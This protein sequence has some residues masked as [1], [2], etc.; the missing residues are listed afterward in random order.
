MPDARSVS[1]GIWVG[2]GGRDEAPALAGASHFLEHLLFKGTEER[3]A[4]EIAEAVDAVGGEMN[5]YTTLE[6]TAFDTRLP[7]GHLELGSTCCATSSPARVPRR[8]PGGRAPGHPRG[9]VD[10]GGHADDRVLGVLA[11]AQFPGTRS[12]GRCSARRETIAAMGGDAIRAFHGEWYRP[13]NLVVACAGAVDH[14][15]VVAGVERRI[16]RLRGG[17]PPERSAP[18][19]P[20]LPLKVLRRRTEQ[21]HLAVGARALQRD[22]PDRIALAVA[23]QA[24]GGGLSS[25]LFQEIRERRGL[26]YSVYSYATSWSDAGALVV[27][28]AT[29]PSRAT[30]VLG[31]VHA[32]LDRLAAGGI[33]PRSSRS[34]PATWRAPPCSASR[35][36]RAAWPASARPSSSPV[37]SSAS[38]SWSSGSGPSPSTTSPGWST[39]CSAAASAPSRSSVGGQARPRAGRAA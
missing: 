36:R 21:V 14:D 23:N 7:A 3:S 25:R 9:A 37:R 15:L 17:S 13:A 6:Y 4:S 24:L 18:V 5:A 1:T 34:P 29:A 8:G 16:G 31:L 39:A 30:E 22:D 20:A 2:V 33:T 12:A 27:Y 19:A 28:A 35:T 26:T 38:T 11:D 10:G 32:E